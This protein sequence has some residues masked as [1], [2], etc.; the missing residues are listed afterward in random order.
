MQKI[1]SV[2]TV[3]VH[4][5]TDVPR[6]AGRVIK[7][8]YKGKGITKNILYFVGKVCKLF[9]IDNNGGHVKLLALFKGVV[10]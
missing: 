10:Y 1:N 6:H 2:L 7:L 8:H 5:L 9:C 4:Q 3:S